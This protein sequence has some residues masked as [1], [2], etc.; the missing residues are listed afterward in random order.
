MRSMANRFA[1]SGPAAFA[2]AAAVTALSPL[3]SKAANAA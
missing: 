2:L 1:L 3:A